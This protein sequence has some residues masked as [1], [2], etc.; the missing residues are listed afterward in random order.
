MFSGSLNSN[1]ASELKDIAIQD[2]GSKLNKFFE[3]KKLTQV[4]KQNEKYVFSFQ[5]IRLQLITGKY[6]DL[7]WKTL[8]HHPDA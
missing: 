1:P 2:N 8:K 3:F 4:R 7:D 5:Y 6:R